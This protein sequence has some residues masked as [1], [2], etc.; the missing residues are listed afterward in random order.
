MLAAAWQAIINGFAAVLTGVLSILPSSPFS[1]VTVP[2]W[3][4]WAAMVG[5][6]IPG[7]EMLSHMVGILSAVVIW[8]GLRY[9]LRFIRAIE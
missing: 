8:Y 5:L 1:T 2:D 9:L 4:A 3:P 7:R 6:F